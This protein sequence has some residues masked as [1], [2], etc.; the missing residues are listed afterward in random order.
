MKPIEIVVTDER[1]E[2]H[3][4]RSIHG[5]IVTDDGFISAITNPPGKQK[6]LHV[7]SGR[8][9]AYRLDYSE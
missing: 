4:L 2:T 3:V 5:L 8:W 1:G 9:I 7:A 6:T